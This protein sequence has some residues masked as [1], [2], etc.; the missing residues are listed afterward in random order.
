LLQMSRV[1]LWV[2][3]CGRVDAERCLRSIGITLE[4]SDV[5]GDEG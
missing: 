1:R 3:I 4:L 2:Q 5:V